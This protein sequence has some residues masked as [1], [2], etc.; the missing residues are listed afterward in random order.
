M[1]DQR[2]FEFS[3][4]FGDIL[5]ISHTTNGYRQLMS[6]Q[7]NERVCVVVASPNPHSHELFLW[8]PKAAQF[9]IFNFGYWGP[10]ILLQMKKLRGIPLT[11]V[12]YAA[13]DNA[14]LKFYPSERD[15]AKLEQLCD[16]P[17]IA[18]FPAAGY[19]YKNIPPHII[20]DL[21]SSILS[22]GLRVVV[23]GRNYIPNGL[24]SVGSAHRCEPRVPSLPGVVNLVD[25]LS[26]P[27][28]IELV[29]RSVGVICCHSS[30]CL[31]SWYQKKPVFLMYPNEV[32]ARRHLDPEPF[33][34]G[35]KYA[36]TAESSFDNYRSDHFKRFVEMAIT[37]SKSSASA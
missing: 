2:V 18:L 35:M 10:D 24:N 36:T 33:W 5:T 6:V 31:E 32:V 19:K 3:P 27:G 37:H 28:S 20:S 11:T 34:F 25:E 21:V 14:G 30:M 26:A 13:E 1:T 4:G 17:F 29:R 15:L 7:P 9:D 22:A 8:H 16:L 23:G 12:P